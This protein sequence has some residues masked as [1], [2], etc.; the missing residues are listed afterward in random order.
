MKRGVFVFLCL[1]GLPA[2]GAQG[3]VAPLNPADD[4]Y[5]DSEDAGPF[6]GDDF[7]NVQGTSNGVL[8]LGSVQYTFLKFDLSPLPAGAIV[9]GAEFGIFYA[10]QNGGGMTTQDPFVFLHYVGNDKW[11]EDTL[12]W[13]A[14]GSLGAAPEA[15]GSDP[16]MPG[17][18][19]DPLKWD[20]FS[21]DGFTWT[22]W[23]G[24]LQDGFISFRMRVES[25]DVNN[26]ANFY[27]KE[28]GNPA[29]WPYL[30]VTYT[31]IPEPSVTALL[32]GGWLMSR[33]KRGV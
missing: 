31:V 5:V 13:T 28:S 30:K 11:S 2:V 23:Q 3:L 33:R 6:G 8:A 15:V 7:L 19:G 22:D 9:T 10:G 27:S 12:N 14:A 17:D 21:G 29:L 32:L 1:L 25:L 26:Y 20:L 16:M 18:V 4:S 24:D